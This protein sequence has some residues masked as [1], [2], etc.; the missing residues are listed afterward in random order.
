MGIN[1]TN[2]QNMLLSMLT[3][4]LRGVL[5]PRAQL[6]LCGSARNNNNVHVAT[7]VDTDVLLQLHIYTQ[8]LQDSLRNID[9]YVAH[10]FILIV[11][12]N[13]VQRCS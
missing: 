1:A 4:W 11:R 12:N 9:E 7:T 6:S 13:E 2:S 5:G 8:C 3:G 10:L